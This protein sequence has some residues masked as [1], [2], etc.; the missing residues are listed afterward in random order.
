MKTKIYLTVL[1]IAVLNIQNIFAAE[2]NPAQLWSDLSSAQAKTR[3]EQLILVR[4]ARYLTLDINGM[5]S[6]LANTPMEGSVEAK[7]QPMIFNVPMPNGSFS[8]FAIV[9]SP[10]MHPILAAKYP[11]IKRSILLK[12]ALILSDVTIG[13]QDFKNLK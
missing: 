12:T 10:V 4:Q 6:L 9:E 3:G 7:T 5:R 2:K 11:M 13:M 1:F 8:R